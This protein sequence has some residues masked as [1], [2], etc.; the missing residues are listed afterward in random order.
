MSQRFEQAAPV[1]HILNEAGYAA[2]FVGGSVRDFYL[3]RDI[4]DVDIA[5]S[6]TPHQVM[7]LFDKTFPIGIEHGTVL[8]R[9]QHND[10]EITTFRSEADY[11]DFRHPS[12]VRF[13]TSIESDLQRRDFTMNAMALDKHQELL[14]P[15]G[16]RVDLSKYLLRTVGRAND[17]FQEDPLRILRGTRFSA[18]L[19]VSPTEVTTSAMQNQAHLLEKIAIE[20][21]HTEFTKLL[22]GR[23]LKHGINLL[24]QTNLH[25][26]LPYMARRS[27]ELLKL[28]QDHLWQ[29]DTNDQRWA[30]CLYRLDLGDDLAFFLKRWRFSK[31]S[32]GHIQVLVNG[33]K[34]FRREHLTPWLI[35][36]TGIQASRQIS[37]IIDLLNSG[38]GTY[39]QRVEA[40][41]EQLPIHSRAELFVDGHDLVCWI[42]QKPGPWIAEALERI[43]KAVTS[44]QVLNQSD[45]I[46]RWV[47]TCLKPEM[48]F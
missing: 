38:E 29:L 34:T 48:K 30:A 28:G 15:Y 9:F 25:H 4:A 45:A 7:D 13:E 19:G 41:I 24:I 42:E 20:R 10:Y 37:A 2:Y 14:D 11:D 47:E 16:G 39:V 3:G 21:I 1:L 8:V 12:T 35:Y 23:Y 6:A 31:K 44:H 33:L 27:D 26:Y 32:S 46:R 22:A 36:R 17:R 43:E 40:M 18:Q 5:T